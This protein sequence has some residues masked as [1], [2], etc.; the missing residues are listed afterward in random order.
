[1]GVGGFHHCQ[2][3]VA[4]YTGKVSVGNGLL[5]PGG[6]KDPTL[7]EARVER[8]QR[9]EGKDG[10]GASCSPFLGTFAGEQRRCQP[11]RAALYPLPS[12]V[13]IWS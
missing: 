10:G 5:L 12:A 11:Q 9:G 2:D 3:L 6:S 8:Q 7:R 1:M 4:A 13:S